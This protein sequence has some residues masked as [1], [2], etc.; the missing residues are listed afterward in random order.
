MGNW[1]S[2]LPTRD[3]IVIGGSAGA[4]KALTRIVSGLPQDLDAAIFVLIHSG[5]GR[6]SKLPEILSRAGRLRAKLAAHNQP[7]EHG[8]IYVAPPDFHLLI[9]NRHMATV[10]G[11]KENRSR[12]AI[13]PLFRSAAL[14]YG[15]RV[16]AVLL[17]G[18]LDDG[19][20]GIHAIKRRGGITIV[21]DPTEA[22]YPA[23]PQNAIDNTSIDHVL[24]ANEIAPL[25]RTLTQQGIVAEGE[26]SNVKED[27]K[28]EVEI[29]G[30]ELESDEMIER[31]ERLGRLSMFTCAECRGTLWELKDGE[32]LR[33]RCHVGHAFSIESLDVEQAEKLEGALWSALR[34]L[35]ERIALARR[36]AKQAR[37]RKS[38]F[39]ARG[40]DARAEEANKH[41]ANIRTM[42]LADPE[43]M[44]TRAV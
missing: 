4:L 25:L 26:V 41:A 8:T 1:R 35:E 9:E 39:V 10:H 33:Y 24:T 27:L 42:L 40:F 38:E 43:R 2:E 7:I 11:P 28:T 29:I 30:Q 3:V 36:L 16:I 18:S 21:Q 31:V 34:A 44:M 32:L 37:E 13:D 22:L 6:E 12:P 20:A 5:A 14:N 23:M 15:P 17:S 19:A